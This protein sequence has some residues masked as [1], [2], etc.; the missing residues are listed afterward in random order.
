MEPRD[1]YLRTG[2]SDEPDELIPLLQHHQKKDGYISRE[3]VRQIAGYLK[4]SEAHI[5][6]V[7]SFYTQFRFENPAEKMIKICLGT[8][9]HV[10]G[11][12][13]L[14]GEIQ[15]LLGVA[16]GEVTPDGQFELQQVA[17]MGC[18]ALAP[19][20]EFDGEIYGKI[21]AA[22]LRKVFRDHEQI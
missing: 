15:A 4:I 19:V 12:Q 21:T 1:E 6:G 3:I 20:I 10:Q 8:A 5:F 17:C 11:G 16:P 22:K 7:A 18:C 13:Q 2:F 9:C 14:V